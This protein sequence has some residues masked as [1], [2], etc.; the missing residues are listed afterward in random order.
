MR[1]VEIER[2]VALEPKPPVHSDPVIG[3]AVALPANLGRQLDLRA[4]PERP[5]WA[6]RPDAAQQRKAFVEAELTVA[7]AVGPSIV[8]AVYL[9]ATEPV[10]AVAELNPNVTASGCTQHF[11][12]RGDVR[13]ACGDLL[14]GERA[15]PR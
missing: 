5:R 3:Q 12:E 14:R 10:D 7:C 8:E 9:A 4:K 2:G 15:P 13:A 1:N 11:L 6:V